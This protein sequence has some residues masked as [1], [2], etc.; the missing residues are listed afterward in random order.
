MDFSKTFYKSKNYKKNIFLELS[1]TTFGQFKYNNKLKKSFYYGSFNSFSTDN[2]NKTPS[3]NIITNKMIKTITKFKSSKSSKDKI[4]NKH[5]Q[6]FHTQAIKLKIR[7]NKK[8]KSLFEKI[9]ISSPSNNMLQSPQLKKMKKNLI[10]LKLKSNKNKIF[11]HIF[12]NNIN[13]INLNYSEK[14]KKENNIQMT[15]AKNSLLDKENNINNKFNNNKL[16]TD[17]ISK[18]HFTT[19]YYP[20]FANNKSE[21]KSISNSFKYNINNKNESLNYII[22][23]NIKKTESNKIS[24]NT[25]TVNNTNNMLYKFI[26]TDNNIN[27]INNLNNLNTFSSS[28]ESFITSINYIQAPPYPVEFREQNLINFYAK[29]RDLRYIKYF[30]HLKKLKLENEKE[31]KEYI[32]F[33][34]NNNMLKYIHFY[35]LFKPYNYSLEKYLFFLKDKIILET[36]EN[37]KLILIKNDLFTEVIK[38][39]RILLQIHKRLKLYL[40]DK[41][42]LLCVKNFNSN[43]DF[44]EEKDKLEFM[45]DLKN[46]EILKNYIN[47][48]S[49]L[50]LNASFLTKTKKSS[51]INN[52]ANN[53][54]TTIIN[55]GNVTRHYSKKKSTNIVRK[56]TDKY[57]NI[58][59]NSRIRFKPNPIF[60]SVSQFN[61]YMKNF[62]I[63]IEKLLMEDNKIGIEVANLRDYYLH[64]KEE[65]R[66]INYNSILLNKECNI[67]KQK[68]YNMKFYNRQLIIY[69]NSLMKKRKKKT[70]LN[71]MKKVTEIIN[72]IYE[73]NNEDMNNLINKLNK[74]KTILELKDLE[75]LIIF[76]INY[77]NEQKINNLKVYNEELKKIEKNKR[78]AIIR[79]KK[80]EDEFIIKKKWQELIEK[81]KKI[82]NINNR[83][84]N[85]KYKPPKRRKEKLNFDE[86]KDSVDISY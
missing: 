60:E 47:E 26:K 39:R 85:I 44:F 24:L 18:T 9:D 65:I 19:T 33:L 70:N 12:D 30:V 67:L 51:V 76:L 22:N 84:I 75:N 74:G 64:H 3:Q 82:I 58:F 50:N 6:H 46:F 43:M 66:K 53:K 45:Q 29:T 63:K 55:Y 41:F 8:F 4:I 79:Q 56:N 35:K 31:K 73:Y 38:K 42:F 36:K 52:Y 2:T 40:N 62:H 54:K 5:L 69:K 11:N 72:G 7:K 1:K 48:L 23:N 80:E 14:I 13:S 16:L 83:P 21:N 37:Q 32:H 77:K 71:I 86:E 49:E 17:D 81:E 57:L 68:V 61:D 34:H 59:K 27:A 20:S 25:E 15:K 78:I 10:N 28:R